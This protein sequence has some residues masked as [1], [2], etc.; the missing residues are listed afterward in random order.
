MSNAPPPINPYD[1]PPR[2]GM[3]GTGKVL[4]FGGIGCVV[5][6]LLCCGA[7]GVFAVMGVRMVANAQVTDEQELRDLTADIVTIKVPDQL[8]PRIGINMRVPIFGMQ[9][10]SGAIYSDKVIDEHSGDDFSDSNVLILGQMGQ[11]FADNPDMKRQLDEFS[12]RGEV[13]DFHEKEV[14]SL[15]I[16]VNDE[17][18]TFM[19]RKG[20]QGEGGPERWIVTGSFQ[21]K[22]GPA[23]FFLSVKADEFSKDQVLEIITSMKSGEVAAS[24]E[25]AA[26]AEA[27][28]K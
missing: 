12:R 18:A 10:V 22:G 4:L 13:D 3:T 17:P 26:P 6:L 25:D 27:E 11:A 28:A 15:D 16:L 1:V 7:F 9:M 2:T 23:V 21:G 24:V 5:V 19:V 20:T 14:D 8:K